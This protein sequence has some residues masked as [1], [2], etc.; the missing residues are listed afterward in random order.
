MC[1]YDL[2]ESLGEGV[3]QLATHISNLRSR[4]NEMEE[5]FREGNLGHDSLAELNLALHA[6]ESDAAAM[7]KLLEG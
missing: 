4:F 7:E 1:N 3:A 6:V 2:I 5:D